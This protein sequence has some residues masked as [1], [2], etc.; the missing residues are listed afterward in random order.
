VRF[1]ILAVYD[2]ARREYL[3]RPSTDD[4][5]ESNPVYNLL[6]F[7]TRLS[8]CGTTRSRVASSATAPIKVGGR[9]QHSVRW[10]AAD[11]PANRKLAGRGFKRIL[12]RNQSHDGSR[13]TLEELG[14]QIIARE[15]PIERP[16]R[17]AV[18][19]G[20]TGSDPPVYRA[21]IRSTVF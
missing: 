17:N 3:Y 9:T 11:K 4:A 13:A 2:A 14:S 1:R 16:T 15:L 8:L 10:C 18:L 21:L 5:G 7:D 20:N 6:N 19:P 12:R